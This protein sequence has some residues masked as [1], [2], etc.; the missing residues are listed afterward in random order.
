MKFLFEFFIRMK[1]IIS[2]LIFSICIKLEPVENE[3]QKYN[4]KYEKTQRSQ[5]FDVFDLQQEYSNHTKNDT[6]TPDQRR[7]RFVLK[8]CLKSTMLNLIVIEL[9]NFFNV[10]ET[11]DNA[12]P[13][14]N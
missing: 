12:S 13:K 6:T 1:L 4:Q 3:I 7:A 10:I 2:E 5:E 11:I 9:I 14:D 8:Y